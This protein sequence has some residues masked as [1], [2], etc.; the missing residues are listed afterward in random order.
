MCGIASKSMACLSSIKKAL[1]QP[2]VV[3]LARHVCRV[4]TVKKYFIHISS[5]TPHWKKKHG[6]IL[7]LIT[8]TW[9]H[10]HTIDLKIPHQGFFQ[11][12]S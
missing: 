11:D 4:P 3:L 5:L 6:K 2:V 8:G 10:F 7:L 12:F 9:C 1:F